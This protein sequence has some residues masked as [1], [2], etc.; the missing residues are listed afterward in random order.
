MYRNST[1]AVDVAVPF[2]HT[3]NLATYGEPMSSSLC[4]QNFY[5]HIK[6]WF[7]HH[8]DGRTADSFLHQQETIEGALAWLDGSGVALSHAQHDLPEI[9]Y[10]KIKPFLADTNHRA[11]ANAQASGKELLI[12][13]TFN[14]IKVSLGER[15]ERAI[16]HLKEQLTIL[17]DGAWLDAI[18]KELKSIRE[19]YGEFDHSDSLPVRDLARKLAKLE[20]VV[21]D[22]Q[23]CTYS[24]TM[25]YPA[26]NALRD[27]TTFLSRLPMAQVPTMVVGIKQDWKLL[28]EK[29]ESLLSHL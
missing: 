9:G 21:M 3:T 5:N 16:A 2:H 1:Q 19:Y 12:Q 11:W 26:R 22:T 25:L 10:Q 27:V 7:R 20:R 4:L 18:D 17:R 14:D 28:V 24:P 29:L 13:A 15:R 23:K 8:A 6:G